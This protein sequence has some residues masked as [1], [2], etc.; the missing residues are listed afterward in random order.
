MSRSV[1]TQKPELSKST[2]GVD[3]QSAPG[4]LYTVLPDGNVARPTMTYRVDRATRMI[5][6][7]AVAFDRVDDAVNR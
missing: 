7:F 1:H 3:D 5:L 4:D 2:Q 6:G